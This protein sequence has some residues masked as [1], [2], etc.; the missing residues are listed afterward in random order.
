MGIPAPLIEFFLHEHNYRPWSGSLL[1]LGRQTVCVDAGRLHD[2]LRARRI[3][4]DLTS[5]QVDRST[6]QAS[7]S[8]TNNYVTDTT[9]FSAFCPGV[10]L[11]AMDVTDYEIG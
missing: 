1:T 11:D 3:E 10:S 9:L 7:I 5:A 2:I 8:Q 6:V 4:W